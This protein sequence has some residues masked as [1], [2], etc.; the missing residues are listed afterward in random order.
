[1]RCVRPDQTLAE[2]FDSRTL[3]VVGSLPSPIGRDADE[4]FEVLLRQHMQRQRLAPWLQL[5]S[6]PVRHACLVL[7]RA[8]QTAELRG[9]RRW[10]SACVRVQSDRRE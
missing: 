7:E 3:M 10:S 1:M 2:K 4:L 5:C 6:G 9:S 8:N